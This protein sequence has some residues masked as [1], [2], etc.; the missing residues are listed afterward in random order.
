MVGYGLA[1][2]GTLSNQFPPLGI[3]RL[4]QRYGESSPM[5]LLWTFMG[6]SRAYTAFAGGMELLGGMLL[7]W[8][9]TALLGACV[10]IGVMLNI[11]LM[12]F[13]YDVPV[14]L[15]SAHLVVAGLCILLPDASRLA[16]VFLGTTA[17]APRVLDHP[18][19]SRATRWIHRGLK[20]AFVFLVLAL[21]LYSL[22]SSER[23][24]AGA[25]PALGEWKLSAL[26]VDGQT[27]QPE[28]GE[29][30]YLTLA[31]RPTPIPS[32]AGASGGS[33]SV[34][35]SVTL[36]GGTQVAATATLTPGHVV[37]EASAAGAS[38]LLR[39]PLEWTVADDELRLERP[40]LQA[41]L[42]PAAHDYLL[43]RRGF[44]WI[45]EHPFNR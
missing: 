35:C 5:G 43:A 44:H 37:F 8:R 2:V 6:S 45:N 22:W 36:I 9:R 4:A 31:A 41:T 34:P 13:C 23:S 39:E 38:S 42:T 20:T 26:R 3:W 7:V 16:S 29:V 28:A 1:K 15:F 33:W 12:N 18:H 10:S 19:T 25:R 40:G 24:T 27:V 21:P 30:Q 17:V 14:K 32:G 11:M